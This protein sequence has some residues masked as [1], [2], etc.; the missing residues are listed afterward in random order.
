MRPAF[1]LVRHIERRVTNATV[2]E[3]TREGFTQ[4]SNQYLILVTRLV[5]FWLVV[6][7]HEKDVTE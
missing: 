3:K 6:W 4:T 5:L 2:T 7:I 1:G